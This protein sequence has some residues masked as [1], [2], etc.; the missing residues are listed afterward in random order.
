LHWYARYWVGTTKKI[1]YAI[2]SVYQSN[3]EIVVDLNRIG[4]FPMPVDLLI[5]KKD[6][7]KELH[8]IPMN[9][10]MGKKPLEGNVTRVDQPT[11]YWVS[12]SYQLKIKGSLE[13]IS[14]IEIDPSLRMADVDRSNNK[15]AR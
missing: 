5:T 11:W 14:T 7:S 6:G 2:D 3:Q 12:P 9:E 8:Y 13:D 10:L 1:D 15:V 4:E